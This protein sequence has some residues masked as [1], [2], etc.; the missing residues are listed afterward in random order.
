MCNSFQNVVI[1]TF[2]Q[3]PLIMIQFQ[4]SNKILFNFHMSLREI[5]FHIS[6]A[7]TA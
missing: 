3:I 6:E 7:E 4:S 1:D 2:K 5:R